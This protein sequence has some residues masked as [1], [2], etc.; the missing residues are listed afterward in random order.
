MT[1]KRRVQQGL[2][3]DDANEMRTL[4]RGHRVLER[5]VALLR[6]ATAYFAKDHSPK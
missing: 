5:E 3:E 4:N 2:S 6:R 1:S